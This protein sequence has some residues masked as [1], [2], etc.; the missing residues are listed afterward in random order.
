MLDQ[1]LKDEQRFS[2]E[3]NEAILHKEHGLYRALQVF[4]YGWQRTETGTGRQEASE[5]PCMNWLACRFG[6]LFSISLLCSHGQP[7][8]TGPL[9]KQSRN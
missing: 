7:T 6:G 5:G 3:E 1:V 4:L 2:E 8:T 9:C